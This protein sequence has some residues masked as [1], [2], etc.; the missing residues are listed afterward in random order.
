MT[1]KILLSALVIF[2]IGLFLLYTLPHPRLLPQWATVSLALALTV[3]AVVTLVCTF[4]LIW[5]L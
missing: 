1:T 5:N 4:I 3:S 2:I